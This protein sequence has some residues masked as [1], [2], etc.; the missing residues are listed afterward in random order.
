METI[1]VGAV[2]IT[3]GYH[4]PV[5]GIR[6]FSSSEAETADFQL[7]TFSVT[8][9]LAPAHPLF[10]PPTVVPAHRGSLP[11]PPDEKYFSGVGAS[12]AAREAGFG[13]RPG[14][15]LPDGFHGLS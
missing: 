13:V 8:T 4:I 11:R 9:F 3:D 14:W 5:N 15:L 10:P 1:I 12:T 2:S 6:G 7:S